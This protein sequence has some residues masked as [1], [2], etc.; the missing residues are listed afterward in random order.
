[1]EDKLIS[2]AKLE[3]DVYT[4]YKRYNI[5]DPRSNDK[6]LFVDTSKMT[7]KGDTFFQYKDE[8]LEFLN[9]P[10]TI[11][12]YKFERINNDIIITL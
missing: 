3:L 8:F 9:E 12:A 4:Y 6:K 5:H 11:G 2:L 10:I 7:K 1:M